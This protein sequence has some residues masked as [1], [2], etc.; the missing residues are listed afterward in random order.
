MDSTSLKAHNSV[1]DRFKSLSYKNAMLSFV[2][3]ICLFFIAFL[4]QARIGF[5]R[6]VKNILMFGRES[7]ETIHREVFYDQFESYDNATENLY[8]K[9][10]FLN[11]DVLEKKD[12]TECLF[13][14]KYVENYQYVDICFPSM[15]EYK[16]IKELKHEEKGVK[17]LSLH[18][19]IIY[20]DNKKTI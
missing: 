9:F 10:G 6:D 4:F 1:E 5:F 16:I 15:S 17:Y 19:E 20:L 8:L 3:T 14:K 11:I 18:K 2:I 13:T 7:I 12:L